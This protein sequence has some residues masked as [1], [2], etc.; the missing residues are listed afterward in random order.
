V[1]TGISAESGRAVAIVAAGDDAVGG[2][3]LVVARPHDHERPLPS[4]AARAKSWIPVVYVFTC[5]SPVSG[6]SFESNRRATAVHVAPSSPSLS[7][8]TTKLPLRSI[9]AP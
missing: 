4:I 7:H 8:V 5:R 9:C 2:A 6:V 3:V 1:F